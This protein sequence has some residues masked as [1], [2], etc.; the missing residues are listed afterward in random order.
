MQSEP[1]VQLLL[2]GNEIMSGDTVDSNSAMIALR[3]A[4]IGLGVYRKVTVG[5]DS[6][7]LCAELLAM[8]AQADTVII[9]GG[10]GP[11]VDDLTAEVLAA[12]AGVELAEHPA[13][14]AHLQDWCA[15]RNLPLNAANRKQAW[16]PAGARVIPNPVGSAVGFELTIGH[17]RVLCTPGVPG[18]LRRML[19]NIIDDL[20]RALARPA[21]RHILR[22]QTFGLGESTA[23]Q[24]IADA[25]PDWPAAVELGFRAG[26]PQMEIKLAVSDAANL[27]LRAQCE[28]QL[29][30]LFG[31]HI[32][33]EG[34]TQLAARV[35]ELLQDQGETLT[36]A[37]SCTGGLI[38]SM[39]TRIPGSSAGFHAGFVTYADE[40]KTAVLGVRP[41]T[42]AAHGAVSEAVVREMALGA[43]QR[44]RANYAIAVSG[45]AGPD[46]GSADKPVGT[47]WLAWG[48][49]DQ[50]QTSCLQ[51]PVERSL[52]QTMVAA[53]GLDMIRRRLL[54]IAS[55]PRYV[56]QRR[57]R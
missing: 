21:Q 2:T 43:L 14:L 30:A 25:L 36:T 39:L 23:Q 34:D 8:V 37:E 56:S 42:L 57:A 24:M 40:I 49:A 9:N 44:S 52:F 27:P 3:L 51:W 16:L 55:E 10:L 48:S 46:G 7:L 50:L 6:N 41:E 29:R 28:Q 5:D 20:G 18:E 12:A 47:V 13:A 15:R 54:G 35:L 26:A 1:Q 38:A 17:C 53:T 19:D 31:D 33:G 45:I 32:I 4:E 22:L 11:T